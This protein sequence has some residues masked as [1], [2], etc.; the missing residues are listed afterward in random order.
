MPPEPILSRRRKRS[1]TI[2]PTIPGWGFAAEGR[3]PPRAQRIVRIW[4]NPAVPVV[5]RGHTLRLERTP[6]G[7]RIGIPRRGRT[8]T[9]SRRHSAAI[10]PW[11]PR[12]PA[13]DP[14]APSDRDRGGHPRADPDH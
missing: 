8:G 10:P 6:K 5:G 14:R 3:E 2:S 9:T 11:R 13:A 1:I 12:P 4:A 7:L